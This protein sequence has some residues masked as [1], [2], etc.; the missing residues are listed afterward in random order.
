MRNS[1]IT[2]DDA[3]TYKYYKCL[4]VKFMNHLKYF[5]KQTEVAILEIYT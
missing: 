5:M 3:E 1:V 2:K 4:T